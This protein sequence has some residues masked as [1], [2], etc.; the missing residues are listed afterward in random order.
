MINAPRRFQ[1]DDGGRR[2]AGY[3]GFV[4]DCAVRSIT[5]ATGKS[6]QEVYDDINRLS[7]M[8]AQ[9]KRV[10]LISSSRNGV[11]PK[12]LD[13]YLRSLGWTW[14]PTMTIGSGCRVHLRAEELPGGNLIVRVSRHMTAMID[15]VIHDIG[16]PSRGGTRC[17]YGYY[18]DP[19]QMN[20]D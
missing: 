13:P 16:N 2:A 15:G 17:V 5:I 20:S 19:S 6:Y 7:K 4:G 14:K 10:H 11:Y 18:Y 9:S 3:K 12:I 8:E 1:F